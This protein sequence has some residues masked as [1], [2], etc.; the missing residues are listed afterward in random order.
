MVRRVGLGHG[1]QSLFQVAQLFDLAGQGG[2]VAT[3]SWPAS[4]G[5]DEQ[6]FGVE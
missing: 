3:R 2:D 5:S 6:K 1:D 4:D